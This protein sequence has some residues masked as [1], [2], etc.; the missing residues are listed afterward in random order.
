MSREILIIMN[1][2]HLIH[3][4]LLEQMLIEKPEISHQVKKIIKVGK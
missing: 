2:I 1:E 4:A 3:N